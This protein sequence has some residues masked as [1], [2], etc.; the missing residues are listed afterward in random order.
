LNAQTRKLLKSKPL[1]V[2]VAARSHGKLVVKNYAKQARIPVTNSEL[3]N[4]K[5]TAQELI[6]S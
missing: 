6:E 4:E 3:I 1:R 2:E 5:T